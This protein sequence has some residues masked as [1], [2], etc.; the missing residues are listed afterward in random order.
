[1]E[2]KGGRGIIH[3]TDR[4]GSPPNRNPMVSQVERNVNLF[5]RGRRDTRVL[6]GHA[7][8]TTGHALT[9]HAVPGGAAM[10]T[11]APPSGS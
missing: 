7:V 3:R 6:P 5:V 11:T 4:R 10:L 9:G 1:M 8:P 2:R